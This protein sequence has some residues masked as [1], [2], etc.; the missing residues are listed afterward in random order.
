MEATTGIGLIS[1]ERLRQI[2]TEGFGPEHDLKYENFELPRAAVA[3]ALVSTSHKANVPYDQ[4]GTLREY[5]YSLWPL[6]RK[7]FKPKTP[8]RDLARAGA[9]IAAEIDRRINMGETP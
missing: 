3:Y 4:W 9:L 7:W 8:I 5:F 6:D 2:S 1:E